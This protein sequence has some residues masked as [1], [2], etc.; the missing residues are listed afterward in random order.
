MERY[1]LCKLPDY[2][3]Y[4]IVICLPLAVSTYFVN[5]HLP[6]NSTVKEQIY[7]LPLTINGT[8]VSHSE[9]VAAMLSMDSEQANKQ[10]NELMRSL[11]FTS[12]YAFGKHLTEQ[13]VD[14][15][16]IRPGVSRAIV[17][18]SLIASI[19]YDPYPGYINSYAGAGGYTMG[20]LA[21]I[22]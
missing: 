10:T 14:G 19:A 6:R 13:L 9:Y 7:P 16:V 17:R 5:N 20:E 15:T 11:N 1:I 3:A 21:R 2:T 18:P 4:V 22:G 12:T 8:L